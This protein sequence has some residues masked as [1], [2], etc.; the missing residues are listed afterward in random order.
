M[1]KPIILVVDDEPTIL[2]SISKI[3]SPVYQVRA[4]ISGERTLIVANSNPAPELILLD[5]SMP[6]MD[7]Y[8]VLLKLKENPA[9]CDIPVIFVTAMET[10]EDEEKGLRLGAVDYITKPVNPAVLLARV[11]NHLTLKQAQDFLQNK[12]EYLEAEVSRRM[13]ENLIIQEV[14]IRALAHLAETRDPETGE[15]ILR[16]Q[17]YVQVLAKHLQTHSRFS[18]VLTEHFIQLLA[19]SAPLHDIG[20]VGIPDSI[21][22]KPGKLTKDE[23]VLMKTHSELG[24]LAIEH[25]EQDVKKPVE[26]LVLAKEIAHWHHERWDG[27]GYPDGLAGD[28]IPISARFMALADVFD[29]LISHRVYKLPMSFEKARDIIIAGRNSQF[30]PDICDAFLLCYK[31]FLIIANKYQSGG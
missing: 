28:N 14:S 1:N 26:F 2:A 27:G 15:H 6:D 23:W 24:A 13:E 9:T 20:K 10:R 22:L 11:K 19:K 16:T 5:V 30:D 12:N 7:G 8:A 17:S 18:S 21:L 25:A 4:A 31:D 29:A 3:L